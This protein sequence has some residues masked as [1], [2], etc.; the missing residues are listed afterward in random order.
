MKR[1]G[2]I[3]C[4]NGLYSKMFKLMCE[5]YDGF[6]MAL[7]RYLY[8][9]MQL[10]NLLEYILYMNQWNAVRLN[11]YFYSNENFFILQVY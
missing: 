6:K 3:L 8:R 4:F 1:K 10:Y 5:F 2:L 9:S 11:L 7:Q